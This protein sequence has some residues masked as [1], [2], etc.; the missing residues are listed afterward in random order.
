[1]VKPS[2]DMAFGEQVAEHRRVRQALLILLTG[3]AVLL[4][5]VGLAMLRTDAPAVVTV[6]ETDTG[7][8]VTQDEATSARAA[9]V[10]LV[11]GSILLVVFVIAAITL[12]AASRSFRRQLTQGRGGKGEPTPSDDVW[13]QHRLP[14]DAPDVTPRPPGDSPDTD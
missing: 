5:T 1:M 12:V 2:G 14:D 8:P 3:V 7:V 9:T 11:Y 10:M 13:S 4:V 6:S